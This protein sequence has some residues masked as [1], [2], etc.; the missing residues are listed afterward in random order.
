MEQTTD[1][2]EYTEGTRSVRVEGREPTDRHGQTQTDTD[3]GG[4]LAGRARDWCGANWLGILR[5][6]GMLL[7][8][9]NTMRGEDKMKRGDDEIQAG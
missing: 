9:E 4:R 5:I 3:G 1:N 2:T 6:L 8:A 7:N